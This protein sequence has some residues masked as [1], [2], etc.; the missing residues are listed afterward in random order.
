MRAIFSRLVLL[1]VDATENVLGN[2]GLFDLRFFSP[3]SQYKRGGQV[4]MHVKQYMHVY[5]HNSSTS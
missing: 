3:C 2:I 5:S 1:F 4:V